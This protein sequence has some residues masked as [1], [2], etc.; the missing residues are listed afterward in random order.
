MQHLDKDHHVVIR[1]V[2]EQLSNSNDYNLFGWD[3]IELHDRDE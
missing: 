3:N 2:R 1:V